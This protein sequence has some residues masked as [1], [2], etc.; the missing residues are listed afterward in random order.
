M[1][2]PGDRGPAVRGR[3]GVNIYVSDED[4]VELRAMGGGSAGEAATQIVR[5]VL[6]HRRAERLALEKS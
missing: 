2:A 1:V 4:E 6:A 5:G 3:R